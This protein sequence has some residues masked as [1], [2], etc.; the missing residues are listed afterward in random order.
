MGDVRASADAALRT[1][2]QD[3]LKKVN[4]AGADS[5][6]SDASI[7]KTTGVV[8]NGGAL[9]GAAFRLTTQ[10]AGDTR[11]NGSA[12]FV[13]V[14]DSGLVSA[15]TDRSASGALLRVDGPAQSVFDGSA[16]GHAYFGVALKTDT[17]DRLWLADFG[18]QPQIRTLNAQWQETP[19]QGFANPFASGPGGAVRPGDPVPFNIQALGSSVFVAYAI[20]RASAD[21]AGAF[22]AGEEDALDAAAER[23]SGDKPA[24]GKLAEFRSDGSLVR[25]FEDQNRLNAPWGMAI[26][27]ATG[28]GTLSGSLLVGNFGGAGRVCAFDRTTGR[29]LDDLRNAQG[30]AIGIEGLWGLQFGNG[31]ALGDTDA[32]YFAAGPGDEIDGVFGSLRYAG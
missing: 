11:F 31:V 25:V 13:F 28:F 23:A 5:L 29:Y 15:W 7:G 8:F 17:W 26:A 9:D 19:T 27:P 20:S 12:R 3:A 24:R 2:T 4:V 16:Q 1:L 6:T 32:L 14:T 18:A 22:D 10:A 30:A 21:D